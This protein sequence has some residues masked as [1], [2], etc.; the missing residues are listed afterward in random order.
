[1][2]MPN[3]GLRDRPPSLR[4]KE[5]RNMPKYYFDLK[6]EDEAPAL[7]EEGSYQTDLE[8]ARLEAVNSLLDLAKELIE[9]NA[10]AIVVRDDD[11]VIFEA[12]LNIEMKRLN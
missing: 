1:M 9:T 10:I 5:N 12:M 4:E 3:D 2:Q 11:G 6:F 8:A 7:D